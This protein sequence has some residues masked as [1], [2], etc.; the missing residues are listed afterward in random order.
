M[1]PTLITWLLFPELPA[2]FALDEH[3]ATDRGSATAVMRAANRILRR[4]VL[5]SFD[6]SVRSAFAAHDQ[7]DDLLSGV[8]PGHNL[9]DRAAAAHDHGPIGDF[10][11]VIH[12]VGHDDDGVALVAQP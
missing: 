2:G 5:V 6:C 8:R 4:I 12:C 3:A 10:H 7:R 1:K 11:D 9:P